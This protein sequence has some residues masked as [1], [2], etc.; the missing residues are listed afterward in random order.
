MKFGWTI[1][2]MGAGF[3]LT[4]AGA[5]AAGLKLNTTPSLP[6]GIWQISPGAPTRGSIVLVCPP[7]T[8][9]MRGAH[10]AGYVGNGSC[11]GGLA[12]LLKPV[13]AVA[14]DEVSVTPRGVAVNGR[15]LPRSAPMKVDG[16]GRLL[17][18]LDRQPGVVPPGEIWLLSSYNPASFDSRYFGPIRSDQIAGVARPL[19]IK[20]SLHD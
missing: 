5:A 19:L 8:P 1:C 20:G 16:A 11:R 15:L 7:D 12:P 13:A 2:A 3:A 10:A 14:G 9:M 6:M 18:T 17:P 4:V